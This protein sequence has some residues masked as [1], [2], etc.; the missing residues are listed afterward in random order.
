MLRHTARSVRRRWR[1]K[2]VDTNEV[3]KSTIEF[4]RPPI[5]A[6]QPDGVP[7]RVGRACVRCKR[8]A[9]K[10]GALLKDR[11]A[12]SAIRNHDRRLTFESDPLPGCQSGSREPE[13]YAPEAEHGIHYPLQ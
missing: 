4:D 9:G 13:R 12:D 7:K 10:S 2:A 8:H 5:F 1:S 6:G 3:T 11:N